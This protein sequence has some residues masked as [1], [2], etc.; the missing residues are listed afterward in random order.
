MKLISGYCFCRCVDHAGLGELALRALFDV[1]ETA[2]AIIT[3]LN[4]L[5]AIRI[6]SFHDLSSA[7]GYLDPY[8]P[9]PVGGGKLP[10]F[11]GLSA[12]VIKE[13]TRFFRLL[14]DLDEHGFV[15]VD[16]T[17]GTFPESYHSHQ[18]ICA[19]DG[20]FVP[21]GRF[22]PLARLRQGDRSSP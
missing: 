18:H 4:R 8:A 17:F 3:T 21:D 13:L 6:A 22:V 20:G 1:M 19:N 5:S 7:K 2:S 15:V 10:W 14:T 9:E 11:K 12:I 16:R